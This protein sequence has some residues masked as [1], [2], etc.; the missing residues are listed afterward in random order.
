MSII[1]D[2]CK[3]DVTPDEDSS[4]GVQDYFR[5]KLNG[6]KPYLCWDCYHAISEWVESE[7]CKKH[8]LKVKKEM[9]GE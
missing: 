5:L 9:R 8:C 6:S 1:C 4:E 7:D 3:A 2:V